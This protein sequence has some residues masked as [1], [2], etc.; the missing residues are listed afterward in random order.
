MSANVEVCIAIHGHH[1]YRRLTDG[2]TLAGALENNTRFKTS[3]ELSLRLAACT[4]DR[5]LRRWTEM[6]EDAGR[7]GD[8]VRNRG[9]EEVVASTT[10]ASEVA[11]IATIAEP[12]LAAL[13]VSA[14]AKE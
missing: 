1:S 7:N 8:V 12:V 14:E 13:E 10:T 3:I 4:L 11:D 2:E 5:Y 9:I 6:A